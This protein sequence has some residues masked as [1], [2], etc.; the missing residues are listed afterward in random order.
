M[1]VKQQP[2]DF[3]VEEL[4]D[5]LPPTAGEFSLYR[6]EKKGWTTPDALQ[7]V[8]RRWQLDL[9]RVSYGGLKDRHAHT[10]Q[11]LTIW[12]G[13]H[14]GLTHG[15]IQV[16]YLGQ[17]A[18]PYRSDDIRANRFRL[19]LRSLTDAETLRALAALQEVRHSGTPNYFDDQRFG[20]VSDGKFVAK[21]MVLG[22]FEVALRLALASPYE[23]DR[24]AQRQEK[25][26]LLENWGNWAECSQSLPR[27]HARNLV[28]YLH[29]HP[30]DFR[31]AIARLRPEFRGLYL[32]AYQSHLWN[33][34][35]A[36]WLTEH[37][38][39]EQL[40]PVRLRMAAAPFHRQLDETQQQQ[41]A[42]LRLPLP[43]ARGQLDA[44][45]QAAALMQTVLEEEGLKREQLKVPGLREVFFSRGDR[46]ALC[47]PMDL[48]G[49]IEH[50]E[51]NPRAKKLTLS[52]DLPRGCYATLLVK[53]IFEKHRETD[54]Q[55]PNLGITQSAGPVRDELHPPDS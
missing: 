51:K 3:F 12:R 25:A 42:E 2:E 39:P 40:V 52:F 27:G 24:A 34:M 19:V 1:K 22:Q 50:D 4:T 29:H 16:E 45:D 54:D 55:K 49:E 20:S 37:L 28:D 8:R 7:A 6:L 38:R 32:S 48:S 26:I 33:R 46:P 17:T 35:L 43:T 11:Y 36:H 31:G 15:E 47:V 53:R 18:R 23:F 10:I 44:A 30:T 13:P 14:H 5:I 9:R 21:A 41:L